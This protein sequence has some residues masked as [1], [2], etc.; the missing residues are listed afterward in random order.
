[1]LIGHDKIPVIVKRL[2]NYAKVNATDA[3]MAQVTASVLVPLA[4]RDGRLDV[5]LTRRQASLSSH[6]S[7]VALPGG[8]REGKETPTQ[9]ALRE[10]EEEIGLAPS[11]VQILGHLRPLRSLKGHLVLPLVG[12][13]VTPDFVPT[14]N[15]DEVESA[16]VCP[17][18]TF[19]SAVGHNRKD[20][21]YGGRRVSVHYFKETAIGHK[22]DQENCTASATY[23]IWGLTALFMMEA[24]EVC[25]GRQPGFEKLGHGCVDPWSASRS[26]TGQ[27][28]VSDKR[29]WSHYPV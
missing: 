10:S 21:E 16:F 14:V 1:M 5:W 24:A 8:K 6:S 12:L 18:E 29:P 26:H 22:H 20:V 25:L 2:A 13:V 9:T 4:L 19:L 28:P 23:N 27:N 15:P 17:L 3:A 7:E 11:S